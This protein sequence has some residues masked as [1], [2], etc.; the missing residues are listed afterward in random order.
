MQTFEEMS[1][2]FTEMRETVITCNKEEVFCKSSLGE[3]LND[4]RFQSSLHKSSG[5]RVASLEY[6]KF[7]VLRLQNLR[8][9]TEKVYKDDLIH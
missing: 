4:G 7:Q 2:Q 5:G 6:L 3:S 1:V 9:E 8:N